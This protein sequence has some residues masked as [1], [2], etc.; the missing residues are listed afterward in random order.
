MTKL[1]KMEESGFLKLV[2]ALFT[3]AFLIAAVAMPDR[4]TMLD[5]FVNIQKLTCKV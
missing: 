3:L 2:F 4:G 1:K 5:G